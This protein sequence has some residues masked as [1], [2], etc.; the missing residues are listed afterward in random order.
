MLSGRW[1]GQTPSEVQYWQEKSHLWFWG[2]SF[3]SSTKVHSAGGDWNVASPRL[4][5]IAISG[6]QS[7]QNA[8]QYFFKS[9][10]ESDVPS[11][12]SSCNKIKT[13]FFLSQLV[14]SSIQAYLTVSIGKGCPLCRNFTAVGSISKKSIYRLNRLKNN[15]N[16]LIYEFDPQTN[17]HWSPKIVYNRSVIL[18][19]PKIALVALDMI[20]NFEGQDKIPTSLL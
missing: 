5:S 7:V 2:N 6:T 14:Y 16:L 19:I 1:H 11:I 12:F 20:S 3:Q 10:L 8:L 9:Q 13:I 15:R 17:S 18:C 4:N